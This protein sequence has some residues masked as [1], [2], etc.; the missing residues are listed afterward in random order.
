MMDSEST[1]KENYD[2]SSCFFEL[3]LTK[4]MW[5]TKWWF[6]N[7]GSELWDAP[8]S[9]CA[10]RGW[11]THHGCWHI[12]HLAFHQKSTRNWRH[13]RDC[14]DVVVG[15]CIQNWHITTLQKN[16]ISRLQDL[17]DGDR[18]Y[19]LK[20]AV[21]SLEASTRKIFQ[22]HFRARLPKLRRKTRQQSLTR[23]KTPKHSDLW[24]RP[25]SSIKIV[26]DPLRPTSC[27]NHLCRFNRE[28][29]QPLFYC[30]DPG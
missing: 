19:S 26:G 3:Y 13:L 17:Q 5:G 4:K 18:P 30:N 16:M 15:F 20:F 25:D 11:T 8:D 9:D 10:G 22:G 27:R 2:V 14:K 12:P 24:W 7:Q 21:E 23:T 29:P 1:K 28:K 6:I